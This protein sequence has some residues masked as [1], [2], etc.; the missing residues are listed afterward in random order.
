MVGIQDKASPTFFQHV[1]HKM[2][3]EFV[4]IKFIVMPTESQQSAKISKEDEN[5]L[6][7]VAG[8]IC[9]KVQAKIVSVHSLLHKEELVKKG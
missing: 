8:Y 3:E 2:F 4:R 1:A 6:R 5:A 9:R 7:Y